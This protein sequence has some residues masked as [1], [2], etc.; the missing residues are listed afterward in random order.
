MVAAVEQG[1]SQASASVSPAASNS[2]NLVG[3]IATEDAI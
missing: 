1:S 2:N 3:G